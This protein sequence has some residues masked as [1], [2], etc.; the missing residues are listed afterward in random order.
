[1]G[2]QETIYKEEYE[3][4]IARI[5]SKRGRYMKSKRQS[6]VEPVFG[7]LTQ[8]MGMRKINTL[9]I[10]QA[11]KVML[12]AAMAYNLKKYVKFTRNKVTSL[13][14]TTEISKSFIIDQLRLILLLSKRLKYYQLQNLTQKISPQ[15]GL[16][17]LKYSF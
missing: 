3:R 12:M 2:F 17:E 10:Q 4:A 14:K 9:G 15:M 13:A 16:F 1:M 8:F 11:N 5:R 7:T 6:T